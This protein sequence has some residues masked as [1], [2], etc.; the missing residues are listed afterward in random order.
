MQIWSQLDGQAR[1]IARHEEE[2]Q[3]WGLAGRNTETG[4]WDGNAPISLSTPSGSLALRLPSFLLLLLVAA[5]SSGAGGTPSPMVDALGVGGV[6]SSSKSWSL[7]TLMTR[8]RARPGPATGRIARLP[9]SL[10]PSAV[11]SLLPKNDGRSKK[12]RWSD[13][14]EAG[15]GLGWSSGGVEGTTVTRSGSSSSISRK[16]EPREAALGAG[17]GG[18]GASPPPPLWPWSRSAASGGEVVVVVVVKERTAIAAAG[19]EAGCG[20]SGVESGKANE[21]TEAR[22]ALLTP[23]AL[24]PSDDPRPA[25]PPE[26]SLLPLANPAKLKL[27]RPVLEL[28]TGSGVT[29]KEEGESVSRAAAAS[30]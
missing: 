6:T 24:I 12:L 1:T 4:G 2:R 7:P 29:T 28:M 25:S 18:R 11:R 5:A 19:A 14:D 21:G 27:N 26:T 13:E 3:I 23:V 8:L 10:S 22:G 9:M 15:K 20:E 16:R 17:E 30:V